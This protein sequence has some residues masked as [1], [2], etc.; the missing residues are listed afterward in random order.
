MKKFS[1]LLLSLLSCISIFAVDITTLDTLHRLTR[2]II[3]QGAYEKVLSVSVTPISSASESFVIGMP[4]NIEDDS[5]QYNESD[6]AFGR[7][8]A[9]WSFMSNST[10]FNI[11]ISGTPMMPIN[12]PEGSIALDYQMG[13]A[14]DMSYTP[15]S[16]GSSRNVSGGILFSTCDTKIY[17]QEIKAGEQLI[18][19]GTS[20]GV[21]SFQSLLSS[22]GA[23]EN[24][25]VG[26]E[27]G[28]IYFRFS[29]EAS[30]AIY[31]AKGNSTVEIPKGEYSAD[32][33][34]TI[35]GI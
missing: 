25:V 13:F 28:G 22:A 8:I 27:G 5:V 16:G 18:F 4:F 7:R 6:S 11:A 29:K 3:L 31:A 2:P 21:D 19:S 1:F 23:F 12:K 34:I 14:F 26:S 10:N 20:L 33:I 30:T 24:G 15:A 32:V 17:G 9:T 35:S